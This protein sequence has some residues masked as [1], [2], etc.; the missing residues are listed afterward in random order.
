MA[1]RISIPGGRSRL[2]S[3]V[4]PSG[5]PVVTVF[6]N[7][8]G[9]SLAADDLGDPRG[10]PVLLLHGGGQTRHSWGTAV[11]A[12]AS[13]GF[14]AVTLDLRGHGDSDWSPDGAYGLEQLRDDLVDVMA[15]IEGQPALVG[16][17]LGGL[18]AL[19]TVGTA[20]V[21]VARALVL[22]DVV[23]QIE[24]EGAMEIRAF[25]TANPQGFASP[26][27]AAEAVAAY[28]PHRPRPRDGG[29]LMK[30]LRL[31]QDGRY[32]WHWDP[33]LMRGAQTI[34]ALER[35]AVLEEAARNVAVATLLIRG[36]RSRVVS[37]DGVRALQLLIPQCEF[38]NI[39]EA[40]HMVAGDA[41]DAFNAPL[42]AFL[43][44][45]R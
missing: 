20:R 37:L 7:R 39:D 33:A 21:P 35:R 9:M 11:S 44:R 18:T 3:N 36:G 26:D 6:R 32:H 19:L 14:R 4:P 34:D 8:S 38:I 15:Q 31:R 40:D 29:G 42:L 10:A 28:L 12:L 43:D 24:M 45:T 17:S 2:I 27:Q 41:N 1:C 25:M 22:V 23:P 16:A 13:R 5:F 30:N